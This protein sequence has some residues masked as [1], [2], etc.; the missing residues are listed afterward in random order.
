MRKVILSMFLT[1][2]GYVAGP[3]NE[4]AFFDSFAGD[5]TVA[6]DASAFLNT[7]DTIMLGG[8]AYKEFVEYWPNASKDE[9]IT[10]QMNEIQKVIFSRTRES[11]EWGKWNNAHLLKEGLAEE[12]SRLK[13]QPGKDMVL[14]G[15]VS[16]ARSFISLGLIDEYRLLMVPVILGNGKRLFE[17]SHERRNMKLVDTKIY[18]SGVA[19]LN[20]HYASNFKKVLKS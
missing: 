2:D 1:L 18:E 7:V 14:F 20:Y 4:L 13:Q 17:S 9:I 19:R 12:I 5:K 6:K 15:G 3:N 10:D 11:V 16:I 8:N